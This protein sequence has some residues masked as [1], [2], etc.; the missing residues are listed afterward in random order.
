MYFVSDD[1]SR[2]V[3]NAIEGVPGSDYINASHINVRLIIKKQTF[4]E[5]VSS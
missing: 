1:H 5:T 2:V 4:T 3:L